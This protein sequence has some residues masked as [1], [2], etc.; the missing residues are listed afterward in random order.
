MHSDTMYCKDI[1]M[2]DA[3]ERTSQGSPLKTTL[4]ELFQTDVIFLSLEQPC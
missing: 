4:N 2:R 1:F 3:T